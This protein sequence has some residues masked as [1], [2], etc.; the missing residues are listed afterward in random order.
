MIG[1]ISTS[2]TL[3]LL[4]TIS[5]ALLLFLH[6]ITDS[7]TH[8]S[9]LLVMQLKHMIYRFKSLQISLHYSTHKVFNVC[10]H[11]IAESSQFLSMAASCP[12]LTGSRLWLTTARNCPALPWTELAKSKSKSKLLYYW[13]FTAKQFVL[14]PGPLRSTTRDLFPNW[15]MAVIV[16]L[17]RRWVSLL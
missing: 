3:F 10:S 2:V 9:P 17:T 4:I 12:W 11:F 5:A 6:F 16:L 15:T 7:Y 13:R 1:F 8:T 14:W